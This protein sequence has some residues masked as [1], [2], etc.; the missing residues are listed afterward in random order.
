MSRRLTATEHQ[1]QS[2]VV[3]WARAQADAQ[4][5]NIASRLP[6]LG[7]LYAIPNGAGVAIRSRETRGG[8][9]VTYSPERIKLVKEGLLPG[10]P[11]LCL[12]VPRTPHYIGL[13][14]ETKT[15]TGPTS[16]EQ[17]AIHEKL[18]RCGHAVEVYRTVDAGIQML[19]M[20][21][22]GRVLPNSPPCGR[23]TWEAP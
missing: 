16:A 9:V 22:E 23:L 2:A 13:Y 1:I 3:E 8:K 21:L 15:Q 17:L 7:L 5:F 14:L 10:I 18:R 6:Y 11:D 12:P 19:L 20:Y 4:K